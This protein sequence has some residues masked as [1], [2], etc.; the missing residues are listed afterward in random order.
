[1]T[2]TT[3]RS[4]GRIRHVNPLQGTDSV[5]EFSSGNTL[6]L[7]CRP[8]G[9]ASWT[10]QTTGEG[11]RWFFH[12]SHRWFYGLRLT[13]Q[14]SPWI[15]DYGRFTLMPTTGPLRVSPRDR[16]SSF[17]RDGMVV[18]PGYLRV[19]LLRSRTTLELTPTTRCAA[20]R[21]TYRDRDEPR[22]ILGTF[23]GESSI[24]ISDRRISGFTRSANSGA[25]DNFAQYFVVELDCDLDGTASGTFGPDFQPHPD[26]AGSGEQIGGYVGLL[27]PES[28]IV[29]ARV[30]TSFI[31]VEQAERNLATELADT[32]FDAVR[33]AADAEWE[34]RLGCIEVDESGEN[35]DTIRTFYTCLYRT[36]LFP[37]T[38]HE[39]DAGGAQVHYSPGNGQVAPGP[40]YSDVGFWDV[41]RTSLPLYTVLFPELLGE[42]IE[43]WVNFYRESGFLPR[44]LSPGERYAMPG[45]LIDVVIADACAKG[46]D[47]FDVQTAYQGLRAHAFADRPGT[48]AYLQR[49]YLPH[50]KFGESVNNTLD[51]LYG[52]FCV[53]RLAGLL[54]HSDDQAALAKRAENYQ[55]LFDRSIGFM[56]GRNEDGSWQEPFDP[57]QW[58]DPFCE[59]SAWQCSWAVPYDVRG[60][61]ELMGGP[62][63]LVAKLDK[64]MS[65]PADFKVGSYGYE[66]HEMSEMAAGGL[67]QFAISNQ[68]S[69]H[70]PFMYAAV[71]RPDR[72][73]YWVRRTLENS[74]SAE[75]DGLPG[76]EDNGSLAA[77]YI[78]GALG[79]YPLCPGVPEYVFGS[80]LFRRVTVHLGTGKDLVIEADAPQHPYWSGVS[81]N[82]EAH[83]QLVLAHDTVMSG[84]TVSFTMSAEPAGTTY[85]ADALPY[86]LT[87]P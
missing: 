15:A 65:M 58:G 49:G 43:G 44:W 60:L 82:G 66:I 46:I 50:D 33:A 86:S 29:T 72:T 3:E 87:Q 22:L 54:G 20:V 55:L 42:M 23:P 2:D 12:P 78:W 36:M 39:Y 47:N 7:V 75:P 81:V 48:E 51:Y 4:T 16:A 84:G 34:D 26:L 8:F 17:D 67:G 74:F 28:G 64:L 40:M 56:R 52:D 63:A 45:T 21:L 35:V 61:A 68:P 14:P 6:P 59:G 70:I 9:M 31:S 32:D 76:D 69:F 18:E 62:D 57:L 30:A 1:L 25:P 24:T 5:F 19:D 27:L 10:P 83:G 85:P 13:H 71:G 80:P 79:L 37:H 11:E 53:A 38:F 41:F 77:W 73:Q